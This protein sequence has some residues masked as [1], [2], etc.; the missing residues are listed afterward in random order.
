MEHHPISSGLA[1]AAFLLV[2]A[3]ATAGVLYA[4]W[5]RFQQV[6]MAKRPDI[7]WNEIPARI[8]NVFIYVLGQKRLPKNGYTYSGILHIFIFGAFVVL[9]VDTINF[10]LDGTFKVFSAFAG[11][12]PGELFHLPGS[13][14]IYQALAD[15][16]RFLCMVGLAMAFINRTVIKPKRLPLTRDAMYTI[17]FIFGLMFFEVLQ[18]GA[19]LTLDPALK[20]EKGYIWFS[21]LVSGLIPADAAPTVYKIAWWGHLLNLLA[22]TNYVPWSKHS[23]VFA[24]PLNIFFMSLEPKGALR[25]MEFDMEDEENMPEY[26]GARNLEDLSWK[27]VFDGLACTECGRCTDNCPAALSDKPLRPMEIIVDLKHHMEDRYK[28][29][30][31]EADLESPGLILTT[32]DNKGIIDPDVLWSCTTCRACMEVCPVGNEH[33]PD[34]IDMRRYLTMGVGEVGHGAQGALKKMGS[35]GNPWGMSKRDRAKWADGLDIPLWDKKEPSDYLYWV[36]CAG[37]YDNRA[38][39]VTQSVTRLMKKAGVDFSILGKKESCTGDS[40]RRLGDEY[41][42]QEMAEKNVGTLDK[43]GVKKIVTHCPHCYNTLKNEYRQFGGEY[44][45][46]HHSEL[47][48]KLMS[49]GKLKPDVDGGKEK[50]VYHDSCYLGRYNDIYDPQRDIIDALPNVTRVEPSRT[51]QRGLCCGAGGGQMWMELDIGK[52]MN[53]VRTDELL[54]TKPDVIAVACNFCMTMVDDG[55]KARGQEDDVQ[56]LDLAELLDRRISQPVAADDHED[57]AGGSVDDSDDSDDSDEEAAAAVSA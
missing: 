53:Y 7:R 17:F 48:S 21:G 46:I 57:A 14:G 15:T 44:E 6:K 11:N 19:H 1:A 28:A 39:K 8:K 29:R 22:F 33:I 51:R 27:Q 35:R 18:T 50:I 24:A 2:M 31:G 47:L 5:M 30:Q 45:V 40:A 49:E 34:I 4:L 25:K 42:F 38:Q 26:F 16:F 32:P 54:E 52:R 43:M 23:H 36:G 20:A 37:A 55:V 13:N 9:S 12:P 3:G 10:V 56:V 41:L